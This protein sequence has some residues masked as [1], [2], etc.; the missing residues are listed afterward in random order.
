MGEHIGAPYVA[1]SDT[2]EDAARSIVPHLSRLQAEVYAI[3]VDTGPDGIT[4]D[5]CE[6]ALSLAHQTCSAR[7]RELVQKHAIVDTGRR[8]K[9]RSGR[10]ARVYVATE[11]KAPDD[12]P[13]TLRRNRKKPR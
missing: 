1:G 11:F 10:A 2:S 12:P 8:R 5:A 4:C 7:V 6:V 3:I 9:T 13:G